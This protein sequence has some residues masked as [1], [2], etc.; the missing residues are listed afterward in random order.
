MPNS[1]NETKSNRIT[2]A[3]NKTK[4]Y[5]K[6]VSMFECGMTAK[7]ITKKVPIGKSTV[8]R[9]Y[10]EYIAEN[11]DAC[12]R[13]SPKE[14]AAAINQLRSRLK[15][16]EALCPVGDDYVLIERGYLVELKND[17][18]SVASDFAKITNTLSMLSLKLSD[19]L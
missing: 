8:Y 2:Y 15:R 14:A 10:E 9:W 16:L 4:Y 5:D 19:K 7:E 18:N 11:K 3:E 12:I 17:I 6:V 13:K 1:D